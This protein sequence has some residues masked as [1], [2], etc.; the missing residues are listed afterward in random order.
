MVLHA[1]DGFETKL[2]KGAPYQAEA[3]TEVV[4]TLGDGNR[5]VRK[6]SASVY[7]DGEGR[8]RREGHLAAIGPLVGVLKDSGLPISYLG[9]G[10]N[11]PDDLQRATPLV[12]ADWV[13]GEAPIGAH[14]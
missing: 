8:S 7:R 3:V 2:V 4:Q 5:I 11:V 10:Q 13:L 1:E 6:T 14:A 12:L 9:F